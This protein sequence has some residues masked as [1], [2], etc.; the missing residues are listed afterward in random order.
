M[1]TIDPFDMNDVPQRRVGCPNCAS[2]GC[3][4]CN[5]EGYV[6]YETAVNKG[7]GDG[8]LLD[9][10]PFEKQAPA[11]EKVMDLS[12]TVTFKTKRQVVYKRWAECCEEC[13]NC[14]LSFMNP[15]AVCTEEGDRIGF[16]TISSDNENELQAELFIQRD[17]PER[18]DIE[19]GRAFPQVAWCRVKYYED[20]DATQNCLRCA[21][22]QSKHCAHCAIAK[23]VDHI[24]IS[25]WTDEEI[26]ALEPVE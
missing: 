22:G 17:C 23:T 11:I 18:L 4:V 8:E 16:A 6:D 12:Q 5:G 14:V 9:V 21:P 19:L 15:V 2:G 1:S 3:K 7:G 13:A 26:P 10:E 24:M 25:S 20:L